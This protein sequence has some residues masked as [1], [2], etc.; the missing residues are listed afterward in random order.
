LTLLQLA[1]AAEGQIFGLDKQLLITVSIQLL[2]AC[3]LAAALTFIVYKPVRK[4]MRNR[5]EGIESQF[6]DARK[7]GEEADEIKALYEQKL[8]DIG[9]ERLEILSEANTLALEKNKQMADEARVEIDAMKQRAS[10]A[11]QAERETAEEEIKTHIV[12][13]AAAMAEKII[14]ETVDKKSTDKMFAQTLSDLADM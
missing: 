1:A 8:E 14:S 9:Q 13:T 6:D 4:F 7:A 10:A 5:T 12:D 2:N 11:I 3:I